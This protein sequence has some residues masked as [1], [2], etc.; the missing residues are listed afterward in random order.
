MVNE[1]EKNPV[2]SPT[3]G[4]LTENLIDVLK[5]AYDISSTVTLVRAKNKLSTIRSANVTREINDL[6]KVIKSIKN[7]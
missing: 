2:T 4:D 7:Y 3:L 5:N 1:S 6:I